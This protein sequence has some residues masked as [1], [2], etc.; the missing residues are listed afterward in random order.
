[1]HSKTTMELGLLSQTT[2]I[3]VELLQNLLNDISLLTRSDSFM[4]IHCDCQP[5]ITRAKNK[6]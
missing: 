3:E 1:M 6:I 4:S 5:D 2:A